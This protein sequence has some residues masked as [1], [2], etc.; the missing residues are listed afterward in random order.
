M[1]ASNIIAL[2]SLGVAVIVMLMSGR[3]DTQSSAAGQAR[4]EAT[5]DSIARGVDD[6]RVEQRVMR[7]DLTKL[8]E[9]VTCAEGCIT[10]LQHDVRDLKAYHQPT[11]TREG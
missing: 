11:N 8:G 4:M 3:K 2:C 7:G 10:E 5:L 6:I 1:T 9:R